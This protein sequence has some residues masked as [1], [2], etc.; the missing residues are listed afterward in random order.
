MKK[1]RVFLL[2]FLIAC[3]LKI[4]NSYC[5]SY[6]VTEIANNAYINAAPQINVHRHITWQGGN[7]NAT[8]LFYYNGTSTIQ[9]TNNANPFHYNEAHPQINDNDYVVWAG[10]DA[11]WT[12]QDIYLF[13]GS[14]VNNFTNTDEQDISPTINNNN[15]M[16][17]RKAVLI[18][19]PWNRWDIYFYNGNSITNVTPNALSQQGDPK[20][21]QNGNIAW[22]RD[23]DIFLYNGDSV[24]RITNNSFTDTNPQ[25]N[26]NGQ[27]V[28]R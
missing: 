11:A 16:A 6:V 23:S 18:G 17:W 9:L 2:V 21:N 14:E 3:F 12:H 10:Y 19:P 7:G 8:D 27:V 25:I 26:A 4:S 15:Q 22:D 20:L 13:N 1:R 28:W 5:D 24:V